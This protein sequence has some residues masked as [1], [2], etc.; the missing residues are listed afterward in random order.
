VAVGTGT[1]KTPRP[2]MSAKS[3]SI[4]TAICREAAWA[5]ENF[6]LATSS[7]ATPA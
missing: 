4:K 6:R 2:R 1:I 3:G 5:P 7:F